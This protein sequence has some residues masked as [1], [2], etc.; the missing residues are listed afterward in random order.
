MSLTVDGNHG[1]TELLT[2]KDRV[3][4]GFMGAVVHWNFSTETDSVAETSLRQHPAITHARV[5]SEQSNSVIT[6]HIALRFSSLAETNLWSYFDGRPPISQFSCDMSKANRGFSIGRINSTAILSGFYLIKITS[7][8]HFQVF[9]HKK[10]DL[11]DDGQPIATI[12]ENGNCTFSERE[13]ISPT[14]FQISSP[15]CEEPIVESMEV[16]FDTS[17]SYQ[18]NESWVVHTKAGLNLFSMW[19]VSHDCELED[20]SFAVSVTYEE[21]GREDEVYHGPKTIEYTLKIVDATFG[22][23]KFEWTSSESSVSKG[24]NVPNTVSTAVDLGEGLRIYWPSTKLHTKGAEWK[25]KAYAPS[26]SIRQGLS[27]TLSMVVADKSAERKRVLIR[28]KE[29]HLRVNNTVEVADIDIDNEALGSF[30]GEFTVADPNTGK[31][32]TRFEDRRFTVFWTEREGFLPGYQ[33]LVNIFPG[34]GSSFVK[35]PTAS[36]EADLEGLWS[37]GDFT[38][39]IA[40]ATDQFTIEDTEEEETYGPFDIEQWWIGNRVE[41]IAGLVLRFAT[42]LTDKYQTGQSWNVKIDDKVD[43]VTVKPVKTGNDHTVSNSLTAKYTGLQSLTTDDTTHRWFVRTVHAGDK[44]EDMAGLFK[45]VGSDFEDSGFVPGDFLEIKADDQQSDLGTDSIAVDGTGVGKRAISVFFDGPYKYAPGQIWQIDWQMPKNSE[46]K[47]L[48]SAVTKTPSVLEHAYCSARG[49]CDLESGSCTCFDG[50]TGLACQKRTDTL[51]S[52]QDRPIWTVASVGTKFTSSV[53]RLTTEKASASDF[54]FIEATAAGTQRFAL[55]GNGMVSLEQLNSR[56]TTLTGGVTI[57]EGAVVVNDEGIIINNGGLEVK[58]G[59]ISVDQQSDEGPLTINIDRSKTSQSFT[60]D[61]LFISIEEDEQDFSDHTFMKFEQRDEGEVNPVFQVGGNGLVHILGANAGLNVIEGGVKVDEGGINVFGKAKGRPAV[62][63]RNS[64]NDEGEYEGDLLRVEADHDADADQREETNYLLCVRK[65]ED[66]TDTL[67]RVPGEGS[68]IVGHGLDIRAGGFDLTGQFKVESGGLIVEAGGATIEAGGLVVDSQGAEISI[69]DEETSQETVLIARAAADPFIN[70]GVIFQAILEE[71][72][73]NSKHSYFMGET[74]VS[75]VQVPTFFVKAS[76]RMQL[77]EFDSDSSDQLERSHIV[78]DPDEGDIFHHGS[79]LTIRNGVTSGVHDESNSITI[80]TESAVSTADANG[81]A[82]SLLAANGAGGGGTG[83]HILLQS[84]DAIQGPSRGGS[85]SLISGDSNGIKGGGD[86]MLF[87]GEGNV[88]GGNI[89]LSAGKKTGNTEIQ[90]GNTGN[91]GLLVSQSGNT[92]LFP[93]KEQNVIF[94]GT[95]ERSYLTIQRGGSISM[96]SD[97]NVWMSSKNRGSTIELGVTNTSPEGN[98]IQLNAQANIFVSSST[99]SVVGNAKDVF[100]ILGNNGRSTITIDDAGTDSMRL[101]TT[102][103]DIRINS[104]EH[105]ILYGKDGVRVNTGESLVLSGGSSEINMDTSSDVMSIYSGTSIAVNS[106]DILSLDGFTSVNIASPN[107]MTATANGLLHLSGNRGASQI[108]L[109]DHMVLSSTGNVNIGAQG[110]LE[111]SG[112]QGQSTITID[113]TET[114][115]MRLH[116]TTSDIRINSGQY[117]IMYGKDGVSVN[118]GG[119][120]VLAGGSSEINMDTSSDVMSIYSSSS[121]AINSG[122]ILT[123]TTFDSSISMKP[124][125]AMLIRSSENMEVNSGKTLFLV[126][127]NGVIVK[128]DIE[129]IGRTNIGTDLYVKGDAN[130]GNDL[131]VTNDVNIGNDLFV[132]GN[133]NVGTDLYVKG[134]GHF[135]NDLFV[136]NDVN[137]GNDLFVTGSANVGTDL[138]VKGD[139]NFGNDLFVTNDVN[140]GNDLFVTGSANVGTDLYVK[141]D[142]NFGNDLFVTNDVNI[143]NDLL[144]T[145]NANVGTD[146]YVKGDGNF[147]NDLQVAG[148]ANVGGVLLANAFQ[149]G[150]GGLDLSAIGS[151]YVAVEELDDDVDVVDARVIYFSEFVAGGGDAPDLDGLLDGERITFFKLG[152]DDD[153]SGVIAE[154]SGPQFNGGCINGDGGEE[155][156]CLRLL[157][158]YGSPITNAFMI[159]QVHFRVPTLIPETTFC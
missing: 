39:R 89:L 43:E 116:T 40:N 55:F 105:L 45:W 120:L 152:T 34:G 74:T 124:G 16:S 58:K 73:V 82:I 5:T 87:G 128:N 133:A 36:L 121:I 130:F 96:I 115:S 33:W 52:N 53:L 150:T 140:I 129:V 27:A 111:L 26:I 68:V 62:Y 41:E 112:S 51:L 2:S 49:K 109:D 148:N 21:E 126:G 3:G 98:G 138:Y 88:Q 11:S 135:G 4:L 134:D 60:N 18:L 159:L 102:T 119:N 78:F 67:F 106:G 28:V 147:G 19:P 14:T 93:E 38:V 15:D 9:L 57:D 54:K 103:S 114:D 157:F 97:F 136:T 154:V 77:G 46:G 71:P 155:L 64:K 31:G 127:A 101:R 125:D 90:Y 44:G 80:K 84:G 100:K 22:K 65:T 158:D 23:E 153:E 48:F 35:Q 141:G 156:F 142:G 117:L 37:S 17:L 123:V 92:Y 118:T 110:I 149:V 50:Y 108:I 20:E 99:G 69:S 12:D 42:N 24:V 6:W 95:P 79:D 1:G 30:D 122:S 63:I 104:G 132:A 107:E 81:G 143:G 151:T 61:A 10:E 139:G 94:M 8:D 145:G 7:D 25:V 91:I 113:D 137:I 29:G 47:F 85:I 86:I 131:F 72:R 32:R 144:L 83:G 13:I 70:D 59:G 76:G 56:K 75:G 146:L 66:D